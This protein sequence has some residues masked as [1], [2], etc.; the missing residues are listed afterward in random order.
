MVSDEAGVGDCLEL[1]VCVEVSVLTMQGRRAVQ[2]EAIGREGF[3]Q[4][5]CTAC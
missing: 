5:Y 2:A 1:E 3:S 4:V